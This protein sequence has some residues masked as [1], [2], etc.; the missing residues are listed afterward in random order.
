V[1]VIFILI[2]LGLIL[3][4]IAVAA[5]FWAIRSGQYDDLESPG[6]NILLDDDRAPPDVAS[7]GDILS[8]E[9]H[10]VE[11]RPKTT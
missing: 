4:G 8:N 9:S 2:P 1:N 7:A 6:W 3:L 11:K 5:F 10:P